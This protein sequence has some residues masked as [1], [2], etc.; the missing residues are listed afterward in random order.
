MKPLRTSE[1]MN[2]YSKNKIRTERIIDACIGML[3]E[4][5]LTHDEFASLLEEMKDQLND[6]EVN[7]VG[8]V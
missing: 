2:R 4:N 7:I 8:N 3:D 6:Q 5:T 1:I